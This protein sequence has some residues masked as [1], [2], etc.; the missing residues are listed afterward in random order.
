M[1]TD[2]VGA[3]L[4]PDES[5]VLEGI[6]R[7]LRKHVSRVY[8]DKQCRICFQGNPGLELLPLLSEH[9]HQIKVYLLTQP[10]H[11]HTT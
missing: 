1:P 3:T 5:K 11:T 7:T 2:L 4:A 8:L 9:A 10:N 6:F